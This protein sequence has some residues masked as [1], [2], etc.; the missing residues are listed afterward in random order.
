MIDL[1]SEIV[2]NLK[3]PLLIMVF[4]VLVGLF[5]LL[6]QKEKNIKE[7]HACIDTNMSECNETIA[8]LVTL[9]EVLVYGRNR[10]G[11]P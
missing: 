4:V 8:K 3:D 9:V 6:L 5:Y 10:N 1:L 11:N 7:L 2:K